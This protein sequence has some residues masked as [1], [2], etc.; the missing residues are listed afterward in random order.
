MES[1]YL[2]APLLFYVGMNYGLGMVNC[3]YGI[4]VSEKIDQTEQEMAMS[5]GFLFDAA[6]KM[7]G[8]LASIVALI[9]LLNI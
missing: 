6:G 7:G 5:L 8:S 3:F 4:R 9:T 2:V 1:L